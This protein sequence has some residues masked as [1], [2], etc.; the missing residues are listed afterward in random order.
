MVVDMTP[1]GSCMPWAK[2]SLQQ[3]VHVFTGSVDKVASEMKYFF[4]SFLS[5]PQVHLEIQGEESRHVF[6]LSMMGFP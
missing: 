6:D 3:Q 1:S 5:K 2:L 4:N